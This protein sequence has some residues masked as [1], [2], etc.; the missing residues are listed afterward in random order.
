MSEIVGFGFGIAI[1]LV[2]IAIP[3]FIV[4]W[5]VKRAKSGTRTRRYPEAFKTTMRTAGA[6]QVSDGFLIER[7]GIAYRFRYFPNSEGPDTIRVDRAIPE[8]PISSAVPELPVMRLRLENDR[9]RLGKRIGLNREL[10]TG[11]T[12]FDDRI[13]IE[14]DVRDRISGRM[15]SS[16][17]VRGGVI[18]LLA[19]G[20]SRI[21]FRDHGSALVAAWVQGAA[22]FDARVAGEAIDRLAQ[23]TD[24]LPAF[25]RT[26]TNSPMTS[27]AWVALSAWMIATFI[28]IVFLFADRRWEP[29]GSGLNALTVRI[30]VLLLLVHCGAMW[31]LVRGHSRAMR[32]LVIGIFAG[33][34]LAPCG[35][36]GGLIIFNGAGDTDITTHERI[37]D[38]KRKVTSDD[39]TS[40][41]FYFPAVPGMEEDSLKLSVSGRQYSAATQG[42]TFLLTVGAGKL[43]TPWLLDMERVSNEP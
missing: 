1:F 6:Q 24:N 27:S 23:I 32:H 12:L 5:I 33:F 34:M 31:A 19:L 26:P 17:E 10:Q 4:V 18:G 28:M 42:D 11:D 22:P 36:R 16:P 38:H 15:L 2:A 13:Y 40:Y 29:L 43:E 25:R 37:L 41:Y 8:T 35:S 3:V 21:D 9:D 14:C 20:F 39:S 7:E 30:G